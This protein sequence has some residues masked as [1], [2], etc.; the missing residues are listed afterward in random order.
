LSCPARG[1]LR[2]PST[3]TICAMAQKFSGEVL[4]PPESPFLLYPQG[5]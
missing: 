4:T 5:V 1:V 3:A 2:R